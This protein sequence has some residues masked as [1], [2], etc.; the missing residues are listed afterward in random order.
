MWPYRHCA[1]LNKLNLERQ[2]L[3]SIPFVLGIHCSWS[4]TNKQKR[5]TIL[6]KFWIFS[7]KVL[8]I[9]ITQC[10]GSLEEPHLR[11]LKLCTLEQFLPASYL[12]F[13]AVLSIITKKMESAQYLQIF[14]SKNLLQ[15]YNIWQCE[16]SKLIIHVAIWVRCQNNTVWRKSSSKDQ[17][18]EAQTVTSPSS[19]E[20]N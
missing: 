6:A 9:G 15:L 17:L 20:V 3:Q 14:R 8:T 13:I 4:Q 18:V 19:R 1:K 2:T 10:S 16:R 7:T 12:E 11:Q 5:F